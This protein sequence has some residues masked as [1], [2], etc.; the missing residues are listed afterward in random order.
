MRWL[1]G[2]ARHLSRRDRR[3]PGDM[4]SSLPQPCIGRIFS[5]FDSNMPSFISHL[6]HHSVGAIEQ[7]CRRCRRTQSRNCTPR[8]ISLW[9]A[10]E[11]SQIRTLRMNSPVSCM[12]GDFRFKEMTGK[13]P[14]LDKATLQRSGERYLKFP[15]LVKGKQLAA[16][17]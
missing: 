12:G 14:I 7:I 13:D 10:W 1:G 2:R 5:Y 9:M 3:L 8:S 4:A 16:R 15:F 11:I 6:H 17:A